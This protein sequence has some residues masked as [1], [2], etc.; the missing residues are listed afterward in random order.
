M[1]LIPS[2]QEKSLKIRI[3]NEA[4]MIPKMTL[5]RRTLKF[6]KN[7]N[8]DNANAHILRDLFNMSTYTGA[9]KHRN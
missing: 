5:K 6:Q 4:K 3:S 8:K 2:N 1:N 9:L 7:K